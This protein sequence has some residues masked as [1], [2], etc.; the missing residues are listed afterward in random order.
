M[1]AGGNVQVFM[2]FFLRSDTLSRGNRGD[3]P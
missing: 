2:C 3:I 1:I